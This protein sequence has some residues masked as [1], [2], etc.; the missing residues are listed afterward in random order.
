MQNSLIYRIKSVLFPGGWCCAVR[1][2]ENDDTCILNNL[3]DEFTV[4]SNS[5]RYWCADPFFAKKDDKY[6]L[7]FEM[8]DR[9]KRKGLLGYR[10]ISKTSIG[11][12]KVIYESDTHLSYPFI[13]EKDGAFFIIPESN[14]SGELFLL[15]C[16]DFPSQWKKECVIAKENLADTTVFSYNNVDYYIS[17]R[18]D[19]TNNFNRI[20]LFYEENGQFKE[21]L[22]NPVKLD[23]STARCAGKI[24]KYDGSYIRP[25]QD[26]GVAYGEKLNFNKIISISKE[27]YEEELI[28]T[29]S[30][31]E[32]KLD[33][34]ESYIGIHTYNRI[35][36]IEVIDLKTEQKFDLYNLVGILYKLFYKVKEMFK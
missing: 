17:E 15:R 33:K 3:D 12:L 28:T 34:K 13:F 29:I 25:S 35:D 32:I 4:L 5:K 2:N 22:N 24:F 26:C 27:N 7:F 8:Y 36:N 20:D 18:V 16:T 31:K 1:F 11:D 19:G 10:E 23:A 30:P 9:L 21:C 14:K 6:Y